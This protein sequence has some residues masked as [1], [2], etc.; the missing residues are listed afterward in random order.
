MTTTPRAFIIIALVS[1]LSTLTVACGSDAEQ[2][3]SNEK[4][5]DR[6]APAP[7]AAAAP[8]AMESLVVE[9]EVV[10][11][12]SMQAA[13]AAAPAPER[14]QGTDE[15]AFQSQSGDESQIAQLVS[16]RRII[17]RTVNMSIVVDEIQSAIDRISELADS[18]G[19]W[20]VSTDRQRRH[21]GT[22]S[23][24]APRPRSRFRHRIASPYSQR[25]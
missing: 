1:L 3:S 10:R 5:V 17:V 12:A 23:L 24:R 4:N 21:A 15:A 7:A 20:V 13:A 9:K 16:Q 22:V 18:L 6:I 14:R 19:G 11:E 2:D 25:R 8:Q